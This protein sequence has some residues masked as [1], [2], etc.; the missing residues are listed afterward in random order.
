M[1][2]GVYVVGLCLPC[3]LLWEIDVMCN[4]AVG[5]HCLILVA[6][7]TGGSSGDLATFFVDMLGRFFIIMCTSL[8]AK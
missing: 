3:G 7:V 6:A 5:A 2:L 1:L 8:L 4:C